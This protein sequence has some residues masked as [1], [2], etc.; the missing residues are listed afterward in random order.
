MAQ[1][2][3]KSG[4]IKPTWTVRFSP[5]WIMVGC[6]IAGVVCAA[7]LFVTLVTGP[8]L[9]QL[10][11]PQLVAQG[12]VLLLGIS[13]VVFLVLGPTLAWGVGFALRNNTNQSVHVI[14]FAVLGLIVGFMLGN[15]I[16]LGSVVAPAAGIGAGVGRWAISRHAKL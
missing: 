2:D 4:K 14:A 11:D 3:E 13:F 5:W 8:G 12:G 16:G 10:N 7:V 1:W 15:F 9:D 6:A